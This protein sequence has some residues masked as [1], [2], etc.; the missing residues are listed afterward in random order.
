MI[1]KYR[2][3]TVIQINKA[4]I[5]SSFQQSL[6]SWVTIKTLSWGCAVPNLPCSCSITCSYWLML[7]N[8]EHWT[9]LAPVPFST[10][11]IG[12]FWHFGCPQNFRAQAHRKGSDETRSQMCLRVCASIRFLKTV[13][14]FALPLSGRFNARPFAEQ[15]LSIGRSSPHTAFIWSLCWVTQGSRDVWGFRMFSAGGQSASCG[16]RS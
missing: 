12:G 9:Y 15:D 3:N 2:D 16:S 14:N 13:T 11:W 7:A 6:C 8:W 10:K 1:L 4:Y 5:F